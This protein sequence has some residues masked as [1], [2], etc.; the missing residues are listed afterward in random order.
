MI[1]AVIF[2]CFGVI[3]LDALQAQALGQVGEYKDQAVL[4]YVRE[5]RAI[6]KTGMLS[7]ISP[8]GLDT[9]FTTDELGQYFDAVIVSGAIGYA[10][11]EPAAYETIAD[12]LG[13]RLD[14]CIMIDDRQDYCDGALAAGMQ[15]VLYQS[16]PQLR[17]ELSAIL[18]H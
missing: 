8:E 18:E 13:V 6:Y 11:P 14:E 7:N 12:Q 5:L 1:K 3:V 2:D 4:D 9:R 10:K 16:L 17:R 15:A